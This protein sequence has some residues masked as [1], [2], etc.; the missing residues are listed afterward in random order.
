VPLEGCVWHSPAFFRYVPA[1]QRAYG[2]DSD[3]GRFFT[4]DLSIPDTSYHDVINDLDIW[5]NSESDLRLDQV[6]EYYNYL[7]ETVRHE[8][9]WQKVR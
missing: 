1:L 4:S 2:T 8:G 5:S 3:L 9:D 7:N 6:Q